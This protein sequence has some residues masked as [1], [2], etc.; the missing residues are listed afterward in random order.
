MCASAR[1]MAQSLPPQHSVQNV[2]DRRVCDSDENNTFTA[3]KQRIIKELRR[4]TLDSFAASTSASN[5]RKPIDLSTFDPDVYE[6]S[7]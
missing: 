2:Q 6:R 7:V 4:Y 1:F 3:H 5:L